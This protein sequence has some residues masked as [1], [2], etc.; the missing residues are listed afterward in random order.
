MDSHPVAITG[1]GFRQFEGARSNGSIIPGDVIFFRQYVE[2]FGRRRKEPRYAAVTDSV[3]LEIIGN[4]YDLV[5][6]RDHGTIGYQAALE[7]VSWSVFKKEQLP[8]LLRI[9]PEEREELYL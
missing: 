3:F 1:R 4:S 6:R 8:E 5:N 7:S 9:P 2:S